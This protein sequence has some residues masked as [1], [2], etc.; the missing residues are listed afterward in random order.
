MLAAAR[1]QLNLN[2][3]LNH[4]FIADHQYVKIAVTVHMIA[5]CGYKYKQVAADVNM[6]LQHWF[7]QVTVG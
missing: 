1:P 7:K 4:S 3:V 5:A 6:W 2:V